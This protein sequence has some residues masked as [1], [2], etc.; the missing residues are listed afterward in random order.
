MTTP[1]KPRSKAEESFIDQYARS[2][3]VEW[4][5][6]T[7]AFGSINEPSA[8]DLKRR[9]DIY[10]NHAVEKGWITKGEPRRLSAKGFSVAAAF[11][12]R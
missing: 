11:L 12:K 2:M 9:L 3:T 7:L 6:Q 4:A 8:A 5:K 1:D 10:F